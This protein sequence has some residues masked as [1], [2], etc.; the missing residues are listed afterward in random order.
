[1]PPPMHV[2]LIPIGS[3]GDVDPFVG[4]GNAL[5]TR[6]HRVTVLTNEHF[7]PLVTRAGLD[8]VPLGTAADYQKA[9][10]DPHAWDPARSFPFLAKVMILDLLRPM[11]QEIAARYEPGNTVIAAGTMA[12]G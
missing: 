7:G 11:Y 2:L 4:I 6:G 12:L 10:E 1:M 8:F 9:Q 5:H 3:S